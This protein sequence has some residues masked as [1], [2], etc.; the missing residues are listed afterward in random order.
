LIDFDKRRDRFDVSATA[1]FFALEARDLVVVEPPAP[2]PV[3]ESVL[4]NLLPVGLPTDA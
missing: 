2:L 3:P 4:T 1:R